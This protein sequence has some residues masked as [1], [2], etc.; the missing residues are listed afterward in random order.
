MCRVVVADLLGPAAGFEP[1]N[2]ESHL[3]LEYK[4]VGLGEE[5]P[6]RPNHTNFLKTWRT[7][8]QIHS[9]NH[10]RF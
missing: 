7:E 10:R 2:S 6:N 1:S 5:P 4:C 9:R 3:A 8:A